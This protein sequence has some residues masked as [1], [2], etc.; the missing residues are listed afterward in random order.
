M[1]LG[2]CFLF[3]GVRE[4]PWGS[5][6]C[7]AHDF[8]FESSVYKFIGWHAGGIFFWIPKVCQPINGHN[9]DHFPRILRGVACVILLF[10]VPRGSV[11]F[12]EAPCCVWLMLF[13]FLYM[14]IYVFSVTRRRFFFLYPRVLP[15]NK[16]PYLLTFSAFSRGDRLFYPLFFCLVRLRGFAGGSLS[17]VPRAWL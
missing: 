11:R 10:F 13:F 9:Y 14:C 4:V 15:A 7:L 17:V 16:F 12:R 5:V 6:V 3:G 2:L 8:F 1:G